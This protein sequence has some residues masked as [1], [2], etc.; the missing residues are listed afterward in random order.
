MEIVH[1]FLPADIAA[2]CM[3]ACLSS[4]TFASG[5]L[6]S[7]LDRPSRITLLSFDTPWSLLLRGERLFPLLS[8]GTVGLAQP[9]T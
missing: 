8:S 2:R 4:R 9:N 6:P 5:K 7:L 3:H 1:N